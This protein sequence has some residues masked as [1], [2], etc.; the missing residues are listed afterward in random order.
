M[1]SIRSWWALVFR[2]F[3]EHRIPFFYFPLGILALFTLSSGSG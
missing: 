2:E 3:I 1:R